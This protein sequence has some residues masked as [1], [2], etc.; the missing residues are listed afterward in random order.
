MDSLSPACNIIVHTKYIKKITKHQEKL[1]MSCK[2]CSSH[3]KLLINILQLK[4]STPNVNQHLTLAH[5]K[6]FTLCDCNLSKEGIK[7][8]YKYLVLEQI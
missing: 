4:L 5:T 6:Y 3:Q 7:I 1:N 2:L 8:L